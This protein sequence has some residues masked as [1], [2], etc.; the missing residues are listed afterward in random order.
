MCPRP[1]PT[2]EVQS[3][4]G[5][6]YRQIQATLVTFGHLLDPG[7]CSIFNCQLHQQ[8]EISMWPNIS[9]IGHIYIASPRIL[10]PTGIRGE[11]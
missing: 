8:A 1:Q 6:Q 7:P 9:Q 5:L 3:L 10:T 11:G 4:G 2:L